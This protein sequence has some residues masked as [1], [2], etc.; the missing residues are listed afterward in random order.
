MTFSVTGE[1]LPAHTS[2]WTPR[3]ATQ[4]AVLAAAAFIYVTAEM[5]P[6]GA[7]P[8]IATDLRVSEGLVATLM[9]SYALV[10][11]LTTVAL[12]RLTARWPRRRTL[13]ATLVCLTVSQVISALAPNFAVLAGGRVLCA[14]AHGLMWSVIAPIGARL[15]PASHAGRATAAVYVGTGLALVVG[16]PLTAALS[17][18]WGWRPA[19]AVIGAVAALVALAAWTMLPPLSPAEPASGTQSKPRSHRRNRRLLT[20]SVL[21]LIGVTGHFVAFT[22]IVVII[23]DVVGIH[24]PH[25][26]WLLAGY[27]IAG[28]AG[29]AAMARPLDLWPKGSVLGCL[30]VLAAALLAL[31]VLAV[32]RL[33]GL[34]AVVLGAVAV[35]VWGAA[36]TALPP[37]LQASAMRTAPEDPDGASGRYVAAFQV[38]IMGGALIGGGIYD[39]GGPAATVGT[40]AALIVVAMCGVAVSRGVFTV[41]CANSEQ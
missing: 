10:A 12:V 28:L 35:V 25:L 16:N 36:S 17:E 8:A 37:M 29:M 22:F 7:L 33:P 32:E 15:V 24:G 41:S 40:A 23:R 13:V 31:S 34:T 5:L 26:A 39:H 30:A 38:G 21:T 3:V 6:V 11:A 1:S 19:V 20:L 2:P 18:L 9:A 4:L 14:L 27:G